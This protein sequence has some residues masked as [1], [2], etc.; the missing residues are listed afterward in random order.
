MKIKQYQD[1]TPRNVIIV[2]LGVSVVLGVFRLIPF[3]V[4][5][6]VVAL[7]FIII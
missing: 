7:E 3:L 5:I 6:W 2:A 4:L 1:N